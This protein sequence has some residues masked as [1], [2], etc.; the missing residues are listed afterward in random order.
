MTARHNAARDWLADVFED[1]PAHLSDREAYDA[2]QHH[3][4]GG[5][6]GFVRDSE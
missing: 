1:C 4:Q 2:I 3:Y 6:A 5:W